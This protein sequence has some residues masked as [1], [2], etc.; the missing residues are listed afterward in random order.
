VRDVRP[1]SGLQDGDGVLHQAMQ[2]WLRERGRDKVKYG[3][4]K[5]SAVELSSSWLVVRLKGVTIGK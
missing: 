4:V 3:Q 2:G 1:D 5:I